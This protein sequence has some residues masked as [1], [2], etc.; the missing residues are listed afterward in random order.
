MENGGG[1]YSPGAS[2]LSSLKAWAGSRWGK[3]TSNSLVGALPDF[4]FSSSAGTTSSASQ[5]TVPAF[6]LP[7]AASVCLRFGR[8]PVRL[9]RLS[10]SPRPRPTTFSQALLSAAARLTPVSRDSPMAK[11]SAMASAAPMAPAA[12]CT[13]A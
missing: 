9:S 2:S 6:S 7:F 4:L 5:P 13:P 11:S 10:H 12:H 3:T 1:V 8:G